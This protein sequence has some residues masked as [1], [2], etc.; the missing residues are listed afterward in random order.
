MLVAFDIDRIS[1]IADRWW[2]HPILSKRKAILEPALNA[3]NANDSV[4][5]IKNLATEIEGIIRDAHIADVGASA[6]IGDLLR[7]AIDRGIKKSESDTTLFFPR[8]F[9]RYL[10]SCVFAS[11]DPLSPT[12][13][14]LS[15]HS[16][17]HGAALG[18]TY[19]QMRALQTI[20]TVDQLAFFL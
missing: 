13:T 14:K 4:S 11:F 17:S 10:N 19:T 2:K 5:C 8:E 12:S 3:F 16:A 1:R 9:L 7:Y 20:L 18:S 15:R 6:K